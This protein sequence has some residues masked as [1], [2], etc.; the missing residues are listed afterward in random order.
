MT[1][2]RRE[3]FLRWYSTH[4]GADPDRNRFIERTR[5][6][7][8][9]VMTK[10][11]V[12]QLFDEDEPFGELAASKLAQ[13]LGLP[14]ETFETDEAL[15]RVLDPHAAQSQSSAAALAPCPTTNG[16]SF[17]VPELLRV[18][19]QLLAAVPMD[20][21]AEVVD[22]VRT[23]AVAPDSERI[24]SRLAELLSLPGL[25]LPS[26]R[27]VA[28]EYITEIHVNGK[29]PNLDTLIRDIDTLHSERVGRVSANSA[30]PTL[31]KS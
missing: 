23:F 7:D 17:A 26:W 20:R 5:D 2:P 31:I 12:S 30:R 15:Q 3:R 19:G 8:G 24:A 27:D 16:T 13:R 18:L 10:A 28:V 29:T 25:Q 4:F 22:L 11:R 21:H 14:A 6:A 9:K 1:N